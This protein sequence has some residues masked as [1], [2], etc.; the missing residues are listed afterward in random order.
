MCSI[1]LTKPCS[2]IFLLFLVI[3][4]FTA[5]AQTSTVTFTSDNPALGQSGSYTYCTAE[6]WI[7]KS[8][9]YC[10]Q[11]VSPAFTSNMNSASIMFLGVSPSFTGRTTVYHMTAGNYVLY[12]ASGGATP[13][14][15]LEFIVRAS[16]SATYPVDITSVEIFHE[17]GS[18]MEFT[19]TGGSTYRGTDLGSKVVTVPS[20]VATTVS[21]SGSGFYGFNTIR[22]IPASNIIFGTNAFTFTDL[23]TGLPVE[24]SYF[25]VEDHNSQVNLSWATLRETNT[26]HY[27]IER[28]FSGNED[29]ISV[30]SL[31]AA[32]NSDKTTEYQYTDYPPMAGTV[33][34]RIRQV[35]NDGHFSFSEVKEINVNPTISIYPNPTS[36]MISIYTTDDTWSGQLLDLFGKVIMEIPSGQLQIDISTLPRGIYVVDLKNSAN[37]TITQKIV[38]QE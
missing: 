38:K 30:G 35:D 13:E 37:E 25:N 27:E 31:S 9:N 4:N 19:F 11:V 28:K 7:L 5:N 18:D 15:M 8:N 22:I 10:G 36:D 24:W 21:L 20:G 1:K 23:D 17:H 29:F 6:G 26:S 12:T 2:C 14:A 33:Q 32:G 34:Y 3:F 16:N